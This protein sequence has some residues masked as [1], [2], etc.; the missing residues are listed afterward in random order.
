MEEKQENRFYVYAYL[1]PRKPGIFQYGECKFDFE[2]F[3]IGKGM[4]DR[5][6]SH[7]AE[8]NY[9][10]NK[11]LKSSNSSKINW[12]KI[13]IILKIKRLTKES[14]IILRIR[15]NL[16]EEES[17]KLEIMLINVIGRKNLKNGPL[18]NL[19]NGGDG[20]SGLIMSEKKIKSLHDIAESQKKRVVQFTLN[21]IFLRTWASISEAMNSL[22]KK[23]CNISLACLHKKTKTAGGFIW[24][25]ESSFKNNKVPKK[26][27]YKIIKQLTTI[28]EQ[29][30]SK[31]I[32]QFSTK[33]KFIREWNN[34]K[35]AEK[36]LKICAINDCLRRK[37]KTVGGFIWF[38]KSNFKNNKI[39]KKLKLKIVMDLTTIKK[40]KKYYSKEVRL[41][42]SK[43]MNGKNNPMYGVTMSQKNKRAL[44]VRKRKPLVQFD[45]VNANFIKEWYS[46]KEVSKKLK[47]NIGTLGR[48]LINKKRICSNS[49]WFYKSEFKNGKI[50]SKLKRDFINK[51]IS[52]KNHYKKRINQLSKIDALLK[53][54][55]QLERLLKLL[56]YPAHLLLEFVLE[57]INVK[58]QVVLFGNMLLEIYSK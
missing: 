2:P 47:I 41:K 36:S 10:L 35:S 18:T 44:S 43:R 29:P 17:F 46:L 49:I 30:N 13:N 8:A 52:E 22:P 28:K 39:P 27:N 53:R 25:F 37:T 16:Q 20:S 38:Y 24:F 57:E 3:Y 45:L 55:V 56:K 15:E 9:V 48:N 7:I 6:K 12:S 21:G 40:T 4:N 32:V 42:Q 33:G 51:L 11:N 54:G 23:Y 1:D 34:I 19:T 31:K 58:R 50:P 5:D 14:P 26:L